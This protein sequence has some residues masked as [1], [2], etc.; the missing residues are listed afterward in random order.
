MFAEFFERV[1]AYYGSQN[2]EWEK[3][4]QT[5][6]AFVYEVYEKATYTSEGLPQNDPDRKYGVID[7]NEFF[8]WLKQK[9]EQ[10]AQ[11][12]R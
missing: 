11:L 10:N 5:Q 12:W 3:L 1:S 2:P 8:E 6:Q 7:Q 4:N 9:K